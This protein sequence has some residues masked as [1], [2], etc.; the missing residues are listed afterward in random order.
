MIASDSRLHYLID[1]LKEHV[2]ALGRGDPR[3][4]LTLGCTKVRPDPDDHD[5]AP[6]TSPRSIP[7]RP[8]E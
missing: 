7:K 6:T 4:Q 1:R 3:R 5:G 2:R 8:Y